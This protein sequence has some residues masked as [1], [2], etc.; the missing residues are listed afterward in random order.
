MFSRRIISKNTTNKFF[1]QHRG[2]LGTQEMLRSVRRHTLDAISRVMKIAVNYFRGKEQVITITPY[3]KS[4][5]AR[6]P[7]YKRTYHEE[8]WTASPNNPL[9]VTKLSLPLFFIE[10]NKMSLDKL[11]SLERTHFLTSFGNESMR[12]VRSASKLDATPFYCTR[13]LKY[14]K[15]SNGVRQSEARWMHQNLYEAKFFLKLHFMAQHFSVKTVWEF[16]K[17]NRPKTECH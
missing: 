14:S 17:K 6:S 7:I 8:H 4:T 2:H 13:C 15:N 12:N 11:T 3:L 1:A 9:S 16:R 5:L 10:M